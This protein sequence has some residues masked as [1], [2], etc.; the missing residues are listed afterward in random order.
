MAFDS[1][2][3]SFIADALNG[4]G[5]FAP[6]VK[7][8]EDAAGLSKPSHVVGSCYLTPY[9]RES[10]K[11]YAARV[12]EAVYEN[13]LRAACEDFAGY[14]S[15]RPPMRDKVTGP[16]AAKFIE[17][18]DWCGNSLDVF[19]QAF[20]VEA[21]ARGSMLLL[22][23]TV[24]AED[25]AVSQADQVARRLFP[26]LVALPPERI[27]DYALNDQGLFD[28]VEIRA[29]WS[30]EGRTVDVIRRWDT[31][32]WSVRYGDKVL[33]GGDHGFGQCPVLAFTE[34]GAFPHV[35]NFEQVAALSKRLY[36]ANSELD[37]ILRG[38]T[39]S[40]LAYQVKPEAA[41]QFSGDQVAAE[42]GT[43]NLL[44]YTGD[45]PGFIA[46]PDG[47]AATYMARIGK[48]EESIR[49]ISLKI[50]EPNTAAAESGVALTIRFE[51]LN[52][53]LT[54]FAQRMED[55]ERRVWVLFMRATKQSIL[56]DIA[57]PKD[58][59]LADVIRELD[60]LTAMQGSGF[61]SEVLREKRKQIVA[62]DMPTLE[63]KVKDA[64]IAAIGNAADE[65]PPAPPPVGDPAADPTADPSA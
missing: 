3:F 23:D 25:A 40:V 32:T 55:L 62:S 47:P 56:P 51:S 6:V 48:L 13:H 58:F 20:E 64:L 60:V 52:A 15:K 39:F 24:R 46:P 29:K 18:A 37:E 4:A 12:V 65:V 44:I 26:Y 63:D 50:N 5:G 42:L 31:S 34:S 11:K 41:A 27:V 8:A 61:P 45:A 57:W 16:L 30:L 14:L 54:A 2:R 19:W 59:A 7:W 33:A 49:R 21:K 36:N 35:G 22:V 1:S 10:P 53:R 43:N 9:P 28:W 38:Q 17:D